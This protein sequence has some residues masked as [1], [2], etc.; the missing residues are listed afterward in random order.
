MNWMSL[1]VRMNL[2][3]HRQQSHAQ[4]SNGGLLSYDADRD[5]EDDDTENESLRL[6]L[7]LNELSDGEL[8]DGELSDGEL[9]EG[10]DD[11]GGSELRSQWSPAILVPQTI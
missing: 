3:G 7:S 11:D 2:F 4:K 8:S 10:D 5:D 9:S 1:T 6:G